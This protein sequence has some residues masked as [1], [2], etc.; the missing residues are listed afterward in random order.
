M[1]GFVLIGIGLLAK[2]LMGL[3]LFGTVAEVVGVGLTALWAGWNTTLHSAS[4]VLSWR[5]RALPKD[6]IAITAQHEDFSTQPPL[7]SDLQQVPDSLGDRFSHGWVDADHDNSGQLRGQEIQEVPVTREQDRAFPFGKRS[8]GRVGRTGGRTDDV[9]PHPAQEGFRLSRDMFVKQHTHSELRLEGHEFPVL[10]LLSGV[11]QG[12]ANVLRGQ[13][14]KIFLG[15]DLGARNPGS[16]QLKDIRNQ[17]ASPPKAGLAMTDGWVHVDQLLKGVFHR[18]LHTPP[19]KDSIL[20]PRRQGTSS[21]VLNV[22]FSAET[23]AGRWPEGS[24]IWIAPVVG[25]LGW[26]FLVAGLKMGGLEGVALAGFGLALGLFG[27]GGLLLATQRGGRVK[28]REARLRSY[29]VPKEVA[30]RY[31]TPEILTLFEVAEQ[32]GL[33]IKATGGTARDFAVSVMT[34]HPLRLPRITNFDV[35]IPL[36]PHQKPSELFN[37]SAYQR[38]AQAF[39]QALRARGVLKPNQKMPEVDFMPG[40]YVEGAGYIYQINMNIRPT[41]ERPEIGEAFSISKLAVKKEGDGFVIEDHVGAMADIKAKRLR[42]IAT[43]GRLLT[44][45]MLGKMLGRWADYRKLG[46]DFDRPSRQLIQQS[47][48]ALR[49]TTPADQSTFVSLLLDNSQTQQDLLFVIDQYRLDEVLGVRRASLARRFKRH[50]RASTA[51]SAAPDPVKAFVTQYLQANYGQF[52]LWANTEAVVDA[53]VNRLYPSRDPAAIEQARE[54]SGI[55]VAGS[56]FT[57]RY[58]DYQHDQKLEL[59]YELIREFL[60][61]GVVVDVGAGKN[62]LARKLAEE[63]PGIKVIGTDV[64]D[65]HEESSDPRVEYRKQL[66]PERVPVEDESADVVILQSVLHHITDEHLDSLLKEVHRILKPGGKV[67]VLENTFPETPEVLQ[68][69]RDQEEIGRAHV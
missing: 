3:A 20:A 19:K 14:G 25:L 16:K 53:V 34:Q 10:E 28:G 59:T 48:N 52:N 30:E 67:L 46:F 63:I 35:A 26:E 43:P 64:L 65:W 8:D 7:R 69:V 61:G 15:R 21:G 27:F 66:T 32:L 1:G 57:R 39:E 37:E 49:H 6:L 50:E 47:V 29:R 40:V 24:P 56:D 68:T 9:M 31:V 36:A 42:I 41:K 58:D 13:L 4:Q 2:H 5:V 11:L 45:G 54:Q 18:H 51:S 60:T 22:G 55:G 12:G 44:E 38:F 62:L 33:K 17:D 23:L